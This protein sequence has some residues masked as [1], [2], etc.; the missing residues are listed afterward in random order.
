MPVKFTKHQDEAIQKYIDKMTDESSVNLLTFQKIENIRTDEDRVFL[1]DR[2]F[3]PCPFCFKVMLRYP[4][5][6][7][8]PECQ[9]V[10][11]GKE[12]IVPPVGTLGT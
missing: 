8:C 12:F 1:F 9:H 6:V 5:T 4:I 2:G 3:V 10:L 7:V 11:H